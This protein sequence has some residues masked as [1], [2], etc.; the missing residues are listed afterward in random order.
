SHALL[1]NRS[2]GQGPQRIHARQNVGK[3]LPQVVPGKNLAVVTTEMSSLPGG[4]GRRFVA[5]ASSHRIREQDAPATADDDQP[6]S[7]GRSPVRFD[8]KFFP[9]LQE[10]V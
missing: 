10:L 6:A 3:M 4:R 5:A 2:I 9:V 7:A 8:H 1:D